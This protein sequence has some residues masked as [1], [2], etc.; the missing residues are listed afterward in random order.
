MATLTS[1]TVDDLVANVRTLLGQPNAVNS[2]WSDEELTQYLNEAVRRY[3]AEVVLR[4]ERS[5]ITTA[6]L[7]CT[8]N[9]ET[10]ALPSDF[11]KVKNLYV[12][13]TGGFELLPYRNNLTN[14]YSTTGG[15]TTAENYRPDYFLR[16]SNI[17][18]HPVPNFTSTNGTFLLEYVS[19]PS[20]LVTGGDAL[21]SH[22][23]PVFKDLIETYAAYKA[24]L[25]E[26]AMSGVDTY[27]GYLQNLNDLFSAFKE[28]VT[29]VSANPTY[30]QAWNPEGE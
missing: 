6:A 17:V 15:G 3:F 8:V 21:T 4:M 12:K 7:D 24:K 16:G 26:S 19:F 23:S 14:G 25:R 30:V 13:V 5:F 28:V 2:T 10:M 18:L 29:Q 11:F 27:S 1:P 22:V 9:V 20:T